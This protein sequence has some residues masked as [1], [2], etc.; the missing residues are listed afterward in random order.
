[1]PEPTPPDAPPPG[2]GGA[3]EHPSAGISLLRTYQFRLIVDPT[4]DAH[5]IYCSGPVVRVVPVQY[6]EGG[7]SKIT[8]LLP[9]PTEHSEIVCKFGMTTSAVLWNWFQ[10][11]LE[12]N[13]ERRN[14][15][16]VMLGAGG[17][18]ERV[19]WNLNDA[20]PCEWR[21][22]PMD[23]LGKEIAIGTLVLCYESLSRGGA[24]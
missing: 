5:F 17:V 18:G 20:W 9:G 24:P 6:R 15:S 14:V 23:A 22:S 8:H 19:R 11:S 7:E 4:N 16:L 3:P 21:A 2:D 12:G 10:K 13:P 1:M